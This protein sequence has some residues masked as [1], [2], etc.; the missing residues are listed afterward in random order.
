L[1]AVHAP[2]SCSV[3]SCCRSASCCRGVQQWCRAGCTIRRT[4]SK[5]VWWKPTHTCALCGPYSTVDLLCNATGPSLYGRPRADRSSDANTRSVAGGSIKTTLLGIE[6]RQNRTF[7]PLDDEPQ[8]RT[9][10]LQRGVG[11]TLLFLP[12]LGIGSNRC[13][14]V[15]GPGAEK[16]AQPY[17]RCESAGCLFEVLNVRGPYAK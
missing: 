11:P 9:E 6:R 13:P 3:R 14:A 8:C 10:S 2:A 4:A 7:I 17:C 15:L 1:S 16:C 12:S 5:A